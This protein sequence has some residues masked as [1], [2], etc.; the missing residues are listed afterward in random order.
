MSMPSPVAPPTRMR[1]RLTVAFVLVAGTLTGVLA[2]TTYLVV[3]D[4]R[5]GDSLERAERETRFGLQLAAGLGPRSDLEQFVEGFEPRGVQAIL[6]EDDRV[7]A[8]SP[9]IRPTIPDDLRSLVEEGQL[10]FA[11]LDVAGAPYL[12]VGGR[13]AGSPAELYLLFAEENTMRDLRQLRSLLL[14]GWLATVAVSGLVGWLVA[15]RT[16]APV[17]RASRAALALAEGLLDTR[18]PV[19]TEDE[20]GAWANSFNRMAEALQAKISALSDA[21]ARERRFTSDVAHEL[22][23]PLTAIVTE[24]S[25]LAEHLDRLPSEA[26]RPAELLIAD[27]ARLRRLVEDLMTISRFD[28]GGE[29]VQLDP[30]ELSGLVDATIRTRGWTE[31]VTRQGEEVWLVSD[32]RRIETIVANLVANAVEHGGDDVSVRVGSADRE[33]FVEVTDHGPGIGHEDQPHVFDRFYKADRARGGGSGLGLSIAL[34]NARLLGGDI[35]VRSE[36]GRGTRMTL[37]IPVTEPLRG[38]DGLVASRGQDEGPS[39]K[40]ASADEA[41]PRPVHDPGAAGDGLR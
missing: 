31:R 37:R 12:V 2:A 19:A 39:M 1:R 16:L 6:V 8:S 10:A 30:V 4:A 20:F 33:A 13:P 14:G 23:T 29:D 27:V 24:A 35:D 5:L 3:R 36:P 32:R 41:D 34:D 15:R 28:A 38:R 18:L 26:A 25:M 7:F 11:R 22:R 40:E 21:Q 9:A 17:G